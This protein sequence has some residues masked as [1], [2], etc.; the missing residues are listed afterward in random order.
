VK[1]DGQN[2]INNGPETSCGFRQL[3]TSHKQAN[4]YLEEWLK[5]LLNIRGPEKKG[6]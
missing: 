1:V 6:D 4:C 3:G 5:L 2:L